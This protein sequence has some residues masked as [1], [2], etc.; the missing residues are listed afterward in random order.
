MDLCERLGCYR[1]RGRGI[2]VAN[3]HLG[4]RKLSAFAHALMKELIAVV[5]C[6]VDD[7]LLD[8]PAKLYRALHGDRILGRGL[9]FSRPLL[10]TL[11][12][13]STVGILV[14]QNLT[15][16]RGLFI[17]FFGRKASA[18][19]GL[20]RLVHCTGAAVLPG[21]APWSGPE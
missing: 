16:D 6:P 20:A 13:D 3:A 5:V 2:L 7:P 15:A 12:A 18:D 4:N 10:A 21:D 8:A 17:E 11:R 19:S 9:H 14:D 1:G